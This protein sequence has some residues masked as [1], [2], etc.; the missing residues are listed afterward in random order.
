MVT[1]TFSIT[2]DFSPSAAEPVPMRATL[3]RAMAMFL[4]AVGLPIVIGFA[5]RLRG[6]GGVLLGDAPNGLKV[7]VAVG[8]LLAA[9]GALLVRRDRHEY[10]RPWHRVWSLQGAAGIVNCLEI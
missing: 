3:R 7:L 8:F 2:L 10:K 9:S 4:V 1:F 5:V 6:L